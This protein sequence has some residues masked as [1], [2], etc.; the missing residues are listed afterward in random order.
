VE[1][2]ADFTQNL[3]RC[4]SLAAAA[5][6]LAACGNGGS[7]EFQPPAT[8]PGIVNN[9]GA[10]TSM[11]PAGVALAIETSQTTATGYHAKL[12]FN[13]LKGTQLTG[14]GYTLKPKHVTRNQ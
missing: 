12:Q 13:P 4:L 8:T 9:R 3:A 2:L 6:V 7:I 5:L 10:S 11:V 1:R 14:S